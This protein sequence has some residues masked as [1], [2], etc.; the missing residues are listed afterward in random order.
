MLP[1]I[2]LVLFLF[3]QL[4]GTGYAAEFRASVVEVD[5]T[6]TTPQTLRGYT[7]RESVSVHDKL[8]HRIAALDDGTTTIYLVSTDICL[9]S[10]G[11]YDQVAQD[12]QRQL[13]IAPQNLWWTATHTHSAPGV[14]PAGVG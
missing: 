4:T 12:V 9:F 2:A 10:P 1:R 5:I 14:G 6:P 11:F 7:P 8:F 3:S 13:G